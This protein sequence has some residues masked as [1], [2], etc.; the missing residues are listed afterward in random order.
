MSIF[1]P[2]NEQDG[3]RVAEC[4]PCQRPKCK[5]KYF[6]SK[7]RALCKSA[8]ELPHFS[9]LFLSPYKSLQICK[10]L[11]SRNNAKVHIEL[12]IYRAWATCGERGKLD[13]L[14]WSKMLSVYCHND[15]L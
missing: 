14:F 11:E 3:T 4:L 7:L 6:D 2:Q 10:S 8:R 13:N 5:D 1:L 12:L 15:Y 9:G